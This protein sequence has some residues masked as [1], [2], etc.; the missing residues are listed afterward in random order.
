MSLLQRVEAARRRA[1]AQ[2]A[3]EAAAA[4]V[5]AGGALAA[6]PAGVP[7]MDPEATNRTAPMG[8]IDASSVGAAQ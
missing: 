4:E 2:A 1:E 5:A 3:A 8:P 7:V 6:G